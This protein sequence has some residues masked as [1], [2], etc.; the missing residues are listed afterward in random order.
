MG[1]FVMYETNILLNKYI[2]N[3]VLPW[4]ICNYMSENEFLSLELN[5]KLHLDMSLVTSETGIY[6]AD[7]V[8]TKHDNHYV[9]D[10]SLHVDY[11]FVELFC[12]KNFINDLDDL[13]VKHDCFRFR[14]NSIITHKLNL[15]VDSI[16]N[17][18]DYSRIYYIENTTVFHKSLDLSDKKIVICYY[19]DRNRYLQMDT[20]LN[21][22]SCKANLGE[23][24]LVVYIPSML[25]SDIDKIMKVYS[26]KFKLGEKRLYLGVNGYERENELLPYF[27]ELKEKYGK[28][29]RSDI[30]LNLICYYFDILHKDINKNERIS[31]KES[32]SE[33]IK[34]ISYRDDINEITDKIYGRIEE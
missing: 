30:Y 2:L 24:V 18:D 9:V 3:K 28:T 29:F 34:H 25:K 7:I 10:G 17:I 12:Y 4:Y 26:S 6:G 5:K 31:Y 22:S 8:I 14:T 23:E 21:L 13:S 1:V 27:K 32:L 20:Y 19:P 15:Y 16:L 11:Y 33:Y